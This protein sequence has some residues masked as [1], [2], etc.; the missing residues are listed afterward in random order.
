MK[1]FL[2]LDAHRL[3]VWLWRHGEVALEHSFENSHEGVARFETILPTLTDQPLTLL[4]NSPE[5]AYQ[6]DTI[7]FLRGAD[8]EAVIRRRCSQF[9]FSTPLTASV[10]LGHEKSRRRNER[11]L[12]SAFTNPAAFEAWLAP[13]AR[14]GAPLKGLHGIGQLGGPLLQRLGYAPARCILLT[15]QDNSV[16]ESFIV[17]GITVFS[18]VASLPDSS[19][20][21]TAGALAAEARKLQQY[22]L[23]Q[24]LIGRNDG[25][26]AYVLA[27]PQAMQT[28]RT[29]C[30][31]S[32][33]LRFELIDNQQAARKIGLKTP[34]VDSHAEAFFIHQLAVLPPAQQYLGENL[35]H[36]YRL[37]LL[38]RTLLAFSALC[39][40]AAALASAYFFFG[41]LQ[42]R[43]ETTALLAQ[44]NAMELR[45]R[46]IATTFPH[47]QIDN[48]ALRQIINRYAGLQRHQG[49]PRA[50]FVQISQVLDKQPAIDVESLEWKQAA[51]VDT[52]TAN[53]ESLTLTGQVR[54]AGKVT[55]RQ[56]MTG[57]DNLV[58]ALRTQSDL[59]V[60]V[61]RPPFDIDPA[62]GIKGNS[63]DQ[64]LSPHSFALGISRK[65]TP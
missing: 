5:E 48:D 42:L 56:T 55:P 39:V 38:K 26:T 10:T 15:L 18:R 34:P 50:L 9:F 28:V 1:R 21:A 6:Q 27:H 12:L 54:I 37:F 52:A 22:L 16:R 32:A 24:R 57:F 8:R 3:S 20:A 53:E 11:V 13:L 63:T 65:E 43:Q 35:R 23:G 62:Q 44:G 29:S 49:K 7:P 60:Q 58:A 25:L 19:L 47:M 61:L 59:S 31:D 41:G 14:V 17:S 33:N 46:G 40:V 4:S 36:D 64:P 45:Y 30:I 51:P 2:Y